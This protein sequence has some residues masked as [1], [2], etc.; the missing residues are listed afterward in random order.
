M[1]TE[2]PH[3]PA[4]QRNKDVIL[5]QLKELF[6]KRESVMEIGHGTG[7][8]ALH[9][10]K[11]LAHLTWHPYDTKDYNWILEEKMKAH[12]IENLQ[13]PC[14]FQVKN[15][16]IIPSIDKTFDA[17]Y[18]ANVF[19][20]MHAKDVQYLCENLHQFIQDK[21]VLYGPY[22]FNGAFTSKSNQEFN[23]SLKERDPHMGIRDCEQIEAWLDK[24]KL[25][26]NISMPANNNLLF[27]TRTE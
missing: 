13:A 3:S 2:L 11:N 10:S 8:H 18:C 16:Q 24:F 5:T 22:K 1:Q 12:P 20:I 7:E 27:F 4:A 9:F 14:A 19:H 15:N 25:I 26:K 17:L 23:Q 21:I 6:A